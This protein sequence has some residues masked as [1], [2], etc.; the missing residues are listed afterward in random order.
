MN[1]LIN[2]LLDLAKVEAKELN[3]KASK[4]NFIHHLKGILFSYKSLAEKNKI[5]LKFVSQLDSILI[6]FDKEMIDKIFNNLLSNAFKYTNE[7]GAITIGVSQIR[8]SELQSDKY[9]S[10]EVSITDTGIGIPPEKLD[11]IFD[12]FYQVDE[13]NLE[14]KKGTG[15]GL[16]I[17]KEMVE[18]HHGTITVESELGRGTTFKLLLPI[19]KKHLKAS[20]IVEEPLETDSEVNQVIDEVILFNERVNEKSAYQY[21][22]AEN[23]KPI[24]LVVEDNS[25][26]R[27][28]VISYLNN[29]Y[30]ILEASDGVEGWNMC[31]KYIPDLIIS[32]V[33]MPKMDGFEF[34]EN[35]N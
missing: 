21:Q 10:V 26:V 9:E 27:E 16:S 24:V 25:D 1:N 5:E 35:K 17:A 23:S 11:K 33:M 22:I 32:D 14:E 2:Q 6:Y 20:E 31:L 4:D 19:G 12:R 13:S 3:L 18:M 15:I 34:C 28:Y 8:T 30:R 29:D 7:G